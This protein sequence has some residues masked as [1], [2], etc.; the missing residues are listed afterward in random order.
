MDPPGPIL[1][2]R[3][4][5]NRDRRVLLLE[6]GRDWRAD[7]AP[8]EMR[9]ANPLRIILPPEPL[10][11][12]WQFPGLMA[13]RTRS[14]EPK[15]YWRGRGLGGSSA[16]NG[17]IAIRGVAAAFDG[18]AEAGCEGWSVVPM[19]C[20]FLAR[21]ERDPEGTPGHCTAT[22]RAN[23]GLSSSA[24]KMGSCRS[25]HVYDAARGSWLSSQFQI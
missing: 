4:S 3:L 24:G 9:S 1:A 23:P 16:I 7:D 13:R 6:A 22:A 19:C 18:W 8:P 25:R 15:L 12:E 20:R 21:F 11:Q 14:Q 5:E 17:Q 10:Q 2:A